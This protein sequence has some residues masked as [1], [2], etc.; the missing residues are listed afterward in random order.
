VREVERLP[1]DHLGQ[2]ESPQSGP[3]QVGKGLL[4][5]SPPGRIERTPEPGQ[6]VP[7][8]GQVLLDSRIS[9]GPCGDEDLER[10]ELGRITEGVPAGV[11]DGLHTFSR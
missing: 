8:I 9:S 2:C 3:E 7:Q 10:G 5:P 6:L 4:P 1:Y 11:D